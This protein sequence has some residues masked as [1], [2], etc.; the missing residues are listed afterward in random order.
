MRRTKPPMKNWTQDRGRPSQVDVIDRDEVTRLCM[1]GLTNR[2]LAQFYDVNET[3]IDRWIADNESFERAVKD[4]RVHADANVAKALY[5]RAIGCSHDD[6]YI[7]TYQGVP[8]VV[9][10]KKHYPPDPNAA[11]KW[12]S[13]RR[14]EHWAEITRLE[15]SG[16]NGGPIE[17]QR[18]IRID[19]SDLS[20]AELD[21]LEQLHTKIENTTEEDD[22]I[23][24]STNGNGHV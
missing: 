3:T 21:I 1:L 4:G 19:L 8:V 2:Q 18:T 9:P 15:H 20:D 17:T 16:P 22:A 24:S 10:T 13:V 23:P 12:L 6:E 5:Q 11:F 14:K 7:S